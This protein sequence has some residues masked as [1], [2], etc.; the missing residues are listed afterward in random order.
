MFR[1]K[2]TDKKFIDTEEMKEK[3]E[4]KFDKLIRKRHKNLPDQ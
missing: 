3:M 1:R 4:K 2:K